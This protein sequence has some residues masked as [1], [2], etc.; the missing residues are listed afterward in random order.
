MHVLVVVDVGPD[1]GVVEPR[2]QPGGEAGQ[3]ALGGPLVGGTQTGA[4]RSDSSGQIRRAGTEHELQGTSRGAAVAPGT[5]VERNPVQPAGEQRRLSRCRWHQLRRSGT[6]EGT[7]SSPGAAARLR[8]SVGRRTR[9]G[10]RARGPGGGVA[11]DHG[12]A[13]HTG[14]PRRTRRSARPWR[15][16]RPASLRDCWLLGWSTSFQPSSPRLWW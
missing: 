11:A 9:P 2:G 13:G 6:P 8:C 14:W 4:R 12:L 15:G 16:S 1:V 3:Q 5:A 7:R 10:R